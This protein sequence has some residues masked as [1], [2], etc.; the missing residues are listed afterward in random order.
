MKVV[1][2]VRDVIEEAKKLEF[3]K[4]KETYVVTIMIL[5]VTILSSLAIVFADLFISTIIKFLFGIK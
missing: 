3:P 2:F 1:S 4:K 5:V